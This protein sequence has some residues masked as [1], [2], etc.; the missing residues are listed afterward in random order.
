MPVVENLWQD[1]AALG[2]V[3]AAAYYMGRRFWPAKSSSGQGGCASGCAGCS[4]SEVAGA[5]DP[6]TDVIPIDQVL[7]RT[8][9]AAAELAD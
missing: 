4:A 1:F 7:R 3:A 9:T 6:P 8:R 2:V 5:T